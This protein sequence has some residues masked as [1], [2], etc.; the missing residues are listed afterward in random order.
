MGDD[1][2]FGP[3]VMVTAASYRFND[4]APVT[5]QLMDEADVVIGSDVW[6]GMRAMVMPGVKIGHGAIIGAGS[7]VTQDVGA[8]EIVAG[9]PARHIGYR[10]V[11]GRPQTAAPTLSVA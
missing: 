8:M 4:G 9:V 11:D 1:I 5:K 7:V 6:L 10:D 3:E 2:L